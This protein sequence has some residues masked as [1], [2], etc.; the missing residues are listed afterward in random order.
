MRRSWG[1]GLVG[2]SAIGLVAG[3]STGQRAPDGMKRH[4]PETR[5]GAAQLAWTEP[6]E[7]ATGRAHQ[8]PGRMNDSEFHYV[9]DPTVAIDDGGRI[10]VAWADQERKDIFFQVYDRAGEAPLET[11]V[12]V[13]R[14]RR[15]FSWLPRV[16]IP[17]RD[18]SHVYV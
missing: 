17:A 3:C 11:P 13:S 8:G 7:V 5:V 4:P 6:I 2:L 18:P 12:N 14:S 1:L 16:A 10:A 9:D 15:V